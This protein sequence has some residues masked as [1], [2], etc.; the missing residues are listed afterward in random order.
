MSLTL[1]RLLR[2]WPIQWPGLSSLSPG[3]CREISTR[4]IE[5][6]SGLLRS[7]SP[8]EHRNEKETRE[9]TQRTEASANEHN[10]NRFRACGRSSRGVWGTGTKGRRPTWLGPCAFP[11]QSCVGSI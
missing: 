1:L 3:P 11:S 6:L 10:V 2:P 7:L 9:Q 5:A 4:K 8:Q